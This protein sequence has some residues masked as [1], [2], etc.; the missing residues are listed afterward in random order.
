VHI[1]K[2][3]V[4]FGAKKVKTMRKRLD[5]LALT[6]KSIVHVNAENCLAH[7]FNIAIPRLDNDPNYESYIR[8]RKIRPEVDRLMQAT[9]VDLTRGE[10]IPE[11]E[12]FQ[13]I[14]TT[15]IKSVS[16]FV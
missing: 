15:D 13:Q 9:G 3:P 11:L 1:V 6:K 10:K 4:G 7:A 2:T 5:D 16:I 14:S 8:G 12:S